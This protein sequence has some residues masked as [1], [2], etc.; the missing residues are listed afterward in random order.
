MAISSGSNHPVFADMA[1]SLVTST[2]NLSN[3]TRSFIVQDTL[4][5]T[6]LLFGFVRSHSNRFSIRAIYMP[7]FSLANLAPLIRLAIF[8]K[9]MSLAQS[10]LPCFGLTSIEKGEKPA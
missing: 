8:W 9:A 6:T 5:A 2:Y 3:R 10:G 1:Q 4:L 7:S